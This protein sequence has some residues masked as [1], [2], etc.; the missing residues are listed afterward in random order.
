MRAAIITGLHQVEVIEVPVPEPAPNG[1]VVDIALCGICGTDI[2]AYQSGAPY[3]PAICGHEWVGTV[4]AVGSGVLNVSEGDRVVVAV[5][6]P[7]GSCS[8]CR[9]GQTMW[10]STVFMSAMGRDMKNPT[11]GGFAP[12]LAVKASRLVKANAK[13][14]DEEAAQVEPATVAFH[15]V[16]ASRIRL[17]DVAVVQGAGPIGLTT[18]Q[19]VKAAGAGEII[20]IEPNVKRRALALELGATVTCGAGAEADQIIREHTK[21]LGA[22]VIYECV[23]RAPAVQSAADLVRRGGSVCMIGL[24]DTPASIVPGVWLVKEIQLTAALAYTHEE[25]DMAMGMVADGRVRLSPIHSS[26]VSLDT[27]A[28]TM[29]D[30]ASGQSIETK[31]LVDPRL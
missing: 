17:G 22:D 6:P 15:A 23:G 2:H 26:T 31:V 3:N 28:S 30:L 5:P 18:L 14:S 21:G 16:R 25:F 8:A 12:R 11:H 1:A 29:A 13:L 19:W 24:S 27:L 9:A 7:C 4:S 20:V 10:C